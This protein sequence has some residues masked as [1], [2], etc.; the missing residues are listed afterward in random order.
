MQFL[1]EFLFI[2]NNQW[3][4]CRRRT[5]QGGHI[6]LAVQPDR[7][8]ATD[9]HQG[10]DE[11][12]RRVR[13]ETGESGSRTRT[14]WSLPLHAPSSERSF[15]SCLPSVITCWKLFFAMLKI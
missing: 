3:S 8:L 11:V 2:F 15:S 1:E 6:W 13:R 4:Q 14:P 5:R 9:H 7:H 10:T 12:K